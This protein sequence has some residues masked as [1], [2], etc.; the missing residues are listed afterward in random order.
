MVVSSLIG[1]F[2]FGAAMVGMLAAMVRLRHLIFKVMTANVDG[3]A[4]T[5]ARMHM[6]GQP[7]TSSGISPRDCS[8]GRG[9]C[10]AISTLG[11]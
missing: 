8:T 10:W 9:C 7:P 6:Q 3:I 4:A 5:L 11:S 2:V 1:G